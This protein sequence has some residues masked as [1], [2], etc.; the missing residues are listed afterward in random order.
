[1]ETLWLNR[2][3]KESPSLVLQEF[4]CKELPSLPAGLRQRGPYGHKQKT[5]GRE[6]L[7][8]GVEGVDNLDAAPSRAPWPG[9]RKESERELR[10]DSFGERVN[11]LNGASNAGT[12]P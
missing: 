8:A 10:P 7:T 9:K 6:L 1:M 5:A 3:K 4:G 12:R 2:Q 11:D